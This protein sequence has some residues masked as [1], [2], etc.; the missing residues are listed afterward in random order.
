MPQ[1][2]RCVNGHEWEAGPD[3]SSVGGSTGSCP[4]CGTQTKTA[5]SLPGPVTLPLS[6][7]AWPELPPEDRGPLPP[8]EPV[9][10]RLRNYE[11]LGE[12]GR[13]GMG[14]V[15]KA[16]QVQ[17]DRLVALKVIRKERLAHADA[18]RRFRRE[19]LA[20][21]RLSH[22]NIVAVYDADQEGDVHFLAMEYVAGV[23]LQ[24]L[25]EQSGPLPPARASDFIRQ[26]ALGLQ[27]AADQALV[28]RDIK[29]SNLMVVGPDANPGGRAVVKILDMGVARLYQ[30]RDNHEDSLTT[31]TRDGAVIGTPD[32][33]APEQLE[34]PHRADI[35][36]D[37]YSLGCTFYFLLA[38]QVPF[39]GGTL[40]QKLDRQRWQTP[41]SVDQLRPE[42]PAAVAA[43]V[44]R[45]MAKHP[46]DRFRSPAELAAALEQLARTGVLPRAHQ[47]APLREVSCL[48]GHAGP[49][50]AAAFTADG[51]GAVSGG[52]DRALRLWD[53]AGGKEVKRF[54][55]TPHEVGCL[56]LA[57]GGLVVAGQGVTVRVWNVATG[58][59]VLRLAGHSDSVSGLDVSRD[60][61]SVLT[62]SADRTLRLWD[63][64]G[65]HELR[66][67]TGHRGRVSVALSPDGRLAASGDRDQALKLWEVR[68]GRELRSFAVP[69]GPVLGV[70]F[71]PDGAALLS[72]HFDTTLRL[73]EVS[74]GRELRRFTGHRQMVSG[75]A[76]RGDGK[77]FASGSHD[78]S[79][80]V[81][82]PASGAELWCGQ[83]HAGPVTAVAFHPD[84]RRLLSAGADG[85][86]R[87]WELPAG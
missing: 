16:R 50:V 23:T 5:V 70:A 34:D 17:P 71:T 86:L 65:G 80:R 55:A 40:I 78:G 3:E 6:R 27:H 9:P 45:L 12:L 39:P 38:G 87:L 72:A 77:L 42:V 82:D 37:L 49:V 28:H 75:V 14:V 85:T 64:A 56:A 69:R 41:P 10:P 68:S 61:R 35:R 58:K 43:V 73:W 32:Y 53:L 59:E 31:L 44:R 1:F 36:A 67:W 83:G 8:V 15:Y 76:V 51:T 79:V 2:W 18:V 24:R 54:G 84:G 66:R 22:P 19:A 63:L 26:T 13:G 20:A 62:G 25:V 11:I 74:S 81:W 29:P 4:V 46:D 52:A 47:P 48:R 57:P 21:A 33:I 7:P 60:G 30:L